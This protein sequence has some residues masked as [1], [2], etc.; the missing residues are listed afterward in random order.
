MLLFQIPN[1]QVRPRPRSNAEICQKQDKY[2]KEKVLI[3]SWYRDNLLRFLGLHK[4]K[5]YVFG[6]GDMWTC[7]VKHFGSDAK[8]F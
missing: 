4:T 5:F 2:F 1:L 3:H 8:R 6:N 7:F